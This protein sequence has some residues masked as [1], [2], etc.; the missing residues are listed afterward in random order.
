MQLDL[1]WQSSGLS[2][3]QVGQVFTSPFL[4]ENKLVYKKVKVSDF[5]KRLVSEYVIKCYRK[6]TLW[7]IPNTEQYRRGQCST[8]RH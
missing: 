4:H 3:Q 2:N 5:H 7:I 1:E 8:A 6:H